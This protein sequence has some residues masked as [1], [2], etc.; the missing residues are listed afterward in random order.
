MLS[1][2]T[3]FLSLYTAIHALVF[4]RLRVV[5]PDRLMYQLA[6]ALFF[7]LMILAPIAA[8]S[9]DRSGH[10]MAARLI[11]WVGLNWMGVIFPLFL[12]SLAFFVFDTVAWLLN[13]ATAL[14]VPTLAGRTPAMV[15]IAAVAVMSVYGFHESRNLKVDR[16][17]IASAKVPI[18]ANPLKIALI[19]DVHVGLMTRESRLREIAEVMKAEK[20]HILLSAGD[21][22]DGSF[23]D[24]DLTGILAQIEAPYGKYAVTGNHEFYRNLPQALDFTTRS[25][26]TVLRNEART[27]HGLINIIGVDDPASG[28]PSQETPLLSSNHNGLFTLLLKHRPSIG[29]ESAGQ[30]DLQLSGHTHGG[31]IW[32]FE[33]LVR[34]A[35]P[36]LDGLYHL[37]KGSQIYTSR[38]TGT[39][40][41][42]M[43]ILAPPV[44][45][46]ITLENPAKSK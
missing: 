12:G 5:L 20:P 45:T 22:I 17:T 4:L 32:P 13:S 6:L 27:A 39:W 42:Q 9:L 30:F 37:D 16:I 41:P 31:Q 18:A 38:G 1:F 2:L 26:F 11:A 46:I 23:G 40:G 14:H 36:Y 21:L 29:S 19:S 34:R 3:L 33:Y 25:G 44:V 10:D 35:Y 8:F 7:L 24:S 15:L 28:M 43:R